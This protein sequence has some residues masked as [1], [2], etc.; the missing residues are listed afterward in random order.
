MGL[1]LAAVSTPY[2]QALCRAAVHTGTGPAPAFTNYAYVHPLQCGRLELFSLEGLAS[3]SADADTEACGSL[4][5]LEA[6][7]DQV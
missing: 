3:H 5:T 6:P 1:C 7:D 2:A 4:C